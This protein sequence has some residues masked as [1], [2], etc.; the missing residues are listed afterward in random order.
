MSRPP[1]SPLAFIRL[2]WLSRHSSRQPWIF[3]V[4]P[5][6]RTGAPETMDD[7]AIT[8]TDPAYIRAAESLVRNNDDVLDVQHRSAQQEALRIPS[9]LIGLATLAEDDPTL[10]AF[11]LRVQQQDATMGTKQYVYSSSPTLLPERDEDR[12]RIR[13]AVRTRMESMQRA[14]DALAVELSNEATKEQEIK[15][16]KEERRQRKRLERRK[17]RLVL[18]QE[19]LLP[20][21]EE[22][23]VDANNDEEVDDDDNESSSR[24]SVSSK[25]NATTD[26]PRQENTNHIATLHQ[27]SNRKSLDEASCVAS[28]I[29]TSFDTT[30]SSASWTMVS[31]SYKPPPKSSFPPTATTTTNNDPPDGLP[32]ASSSPDG[33]LSS[34]SRDEVLLVVPPPSET[35]QQQVSNAAEMSSPGSQITVTPNH[36]HQQQDDEELVVVRRLRQELDL[37]RHK[38]DQLRAQLHDKDIMLQSLQLRLYISDTRLQTYET[39]LQDHVDQVRCNTAASTATREATTSSSPN[40]KNIRG[41]CHEESKLLHRGVVPHDD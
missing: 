1:W 39:A 33:S 24:T 9:R 20:P 32:E 11:L 19:Q 27:T 6:R 41:G 16:S 28:S 3:V 34:R 23:K 21:V 18:R 17:A 7:G 40:N 8:T 35:T 15:T 26:E 36:Q 29:S 2:A 13:A 37:E 38:N 30:T 4:D 10:F 25:R 31:K 5:Y 22:P 12:D 14:A